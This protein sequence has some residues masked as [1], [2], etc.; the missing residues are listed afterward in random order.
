MKK[1][2]IFGGSRFFGTDLVRLLLDAG[3]EVTL[4]TRGKTQDPFGDSVNHVVI[5]RIKEDT[6]K[7]IASQH[8]DLVYD[9]ICYSSNGADVT[10]RLL[11]DKVDHYVHTS[12]GSVYDHLDDFSDLTE[13]KFNPT[14]YPIKMAWYGE[15][16][17]G[18]GKRLAEAVYFQR[19]SFPV[20]AVRF[21]IV[22]GINDYTERFK[23]HVDKIK[24]GKEI[25]FHNSQLAMPL[26]SEEDAG[27]ALFHIGE[28]RLSGTF[29]AISGI[30]KISKILKLIEE[31]TGK[32]AL[33]VDAK[34]EDNESPYNTE[35]NF[36]MNNTKLKCTGWKPQHEDIEAYLRKLVHD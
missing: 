23:F 32:P 13:D 33:L 10:T 28:N 20:S 12:T 11:K 5:D 24:E 17:Y 31:E 25:F 27:S 6:I 29:N 7:S 9:Q 34:T 18:E 2:L 22:V 30:I 15:F 8:W 26:I 21:P 19:A 3:H 36:E 4:A 14:N 1:V 16:D 35:D